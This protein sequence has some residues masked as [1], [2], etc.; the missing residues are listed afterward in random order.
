MKKIVALI[1]TTFLVFSCAGYSIKS[2][3]PSQT[4]TIDVGNDSAWVF[5]AKDK[6]IVI[7]MP[8]GARFY[9]QNQPTSTQHDDSLG[10][11]G[12]KLHIDGSY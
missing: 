11:Y 5:H 8:Y 10:F 12:L 9:N 6:I 7:R 2:L 3:M 4:M 1:L